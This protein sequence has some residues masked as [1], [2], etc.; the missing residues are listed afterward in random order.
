MLLRGLQTKDWNPLQIEMNKQITKRTWNERHG[1]HDWNKDGFKVYLGCYL[2][3]VTISP[4]PHSNFLQTTWT[5]NKMDID[6]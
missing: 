6:N 4:D 1:K 5:K 3:A 2:K